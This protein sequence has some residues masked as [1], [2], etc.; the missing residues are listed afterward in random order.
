MNCFWRWRRVVR[1]YC[2]DVGRCR[3][4]RFPTTD[5]GVFLYVPPRL[6]VHPQLP[7]SR[8]ARTDSCRDRN[9]L[10]VCRKEGT[11]NP[12]LWVQV[13]SYLVNNALPGDA[14]QL[15][16]ATD[17][18]G[19]GGGRG[20][21]SAAARNGEGADGGGDAD[22]SSED[23]DDGDG[24]G[25]GRWDDV[26]EL[27]ALIERDQVLSPLRVSDCD[28]ECD[29]SVDVVGSAVFSCFFFFLLWW[30]WFVACWVVTKMLSILPL[31]WRWRPWL[32]VALVVRFGL[33]TVVI[34]IIAHTP[35]PTFKV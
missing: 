2:S 4:V 24:R 7:L 14:D 34:G 3:R 16:P 31:L 19:G 13:L 27:L 18:D 25:E 23:G 9:M 8:F 10:R 12:D 33:T 11:N 29:R 5:S 20:G 15:S 28:C 26:R 17:K 21:K 30:S 32:S 22:E 6:D 35:G 1:C